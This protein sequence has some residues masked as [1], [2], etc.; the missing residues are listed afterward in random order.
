MR[1]HQEE[2]EE[3]KEL[4]KTLFRCISL[5]FIFIFAFYIC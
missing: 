2:E 3:D 1:R 5:M 4:I